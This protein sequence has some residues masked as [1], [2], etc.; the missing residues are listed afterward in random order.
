[1]VAKRGYNAVTVEL[2]IKRSRVSFKTFYLHFPSK[3]ACF[4][5][6]FDSFTA[7]A[8]KAAVAALA[9]EPDA[10]W[11]RQVV[12]ALHAIFETIL[13]DPLIARATIVEALTVGPVIAKRYQMG[14]NGLSP[15]F[16]RGRKFN[17]AA[18]ALPATLEDT[19]AGG[20]LWS[21]YQRLIVGEVDR[22]EALM[23][24]AIEFVLRPYLGEAEAAS[25]AHSIEDQAGKGTSTVSE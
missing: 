14:M 20:V 1:L 15:L 4:L 17:P 19:L 12:I 9:A 3:E 16:A 23:P 5:E 11:P 22:I 10:P 7:G 8:R 25:W 6:L 13:A 18:E 21:A 2:I 24:E